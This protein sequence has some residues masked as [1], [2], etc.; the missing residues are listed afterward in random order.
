MPCYFYKVNLLFFYTL[1][2]K[3]NVSNAYVKPS[4]VLSPVEKKDK[5]LIADDIISW[6]IYLN[7]DDIIFAST[8]PLD[9]EA[10]IK[11][12]DQI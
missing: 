12:I 4:L 7:N 8:P 2:Q 11:A 5:F 1:P 6:Y 9:D 10:L 3:E